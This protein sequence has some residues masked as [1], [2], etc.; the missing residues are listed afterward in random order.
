M[1]RND[2]GS[3]DLWAVSPGNN[4][5][6]WEY[7]VYRHLD[8]NGNW[9]KEKTV[10]K[11]TANSDDCYST[12]DPGVIYF[13]G[14]YYL[15]YTSTSALSSRMILFTSI[16]HITLSMAVIPVSLLLIHQITG[17][18]PSRAIIRL[19]LSKTKDRIHLMSSILMKLTVS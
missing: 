9:S 10:L 14:Y 2:D 1:I 6:M 12:C 5:T 13:N 17:L 19:S 11:P 7:I 18:P 4:S 16:I 3:V 15:G 8:N